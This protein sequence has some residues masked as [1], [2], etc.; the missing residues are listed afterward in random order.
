[1]LK[2]VGRK[3]KDYKHEL[4]SKYKTANRTQEEIASDV[5]P[6]CATIIDRSYSQLVFGEKWGSI[7]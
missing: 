6:N 7:Y 4:K 5:P 2:S 3:W 1:M